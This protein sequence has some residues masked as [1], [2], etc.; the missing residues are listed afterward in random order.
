[1]EFLEE[2]EPVFALERLSSVPTPEPI[3]VCKCLLSAESSEEEVISERKKFVLSIVSRTENYLREHRIPELIRFILT[4]IIATQSKSKGSMNIADY[5]V[6]LL[7]E[8]MLFRA[9]LGA[10]PVLFEER[11]L[12]A[13]INS[14]DPNDRG[15]LSAGQVRR[16]FMTLGLSLEDL[17]LDEKIPT[18]IVLKL[19]E[20][21]QEQELHNLLVAGIP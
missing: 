19:L 1:M 4:K 16:A 18:D 8:C 12:K 2:E 21:V 10:A 9:G 20:T 7:D 5:I 11:H 3:E 17:K 13:V 14:F 6:Q 15:W